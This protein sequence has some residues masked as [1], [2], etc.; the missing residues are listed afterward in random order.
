MRRAPTFLQRCETKRGIYALLK[1]KNASPLGNKK[2]FAER[3]AAAGVHCVACELAIDGSDVDPALLPDCDLFVKPLT[4]CGGKGAERWDRTGPR[5]WSNGS[6]EFG[7]QDLLRELRSR[8]RTL[9]IQRRVCPHPK[10]EA[11]HSDLLDRFC[12]PLLER[13]PEFSLKRGLQLV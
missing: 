10:L 13:R 11:L 3:C 7:D 9:I 5:I 6:H 8:R 1:R 4:G 12:E 2:A